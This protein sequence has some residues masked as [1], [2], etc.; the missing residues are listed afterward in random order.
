MD[1]DHVGQYAISVGAWEV[2]GRRQSPGGQ[3]RDLVSWQDPRY[4]SGSVA[5]SSLTSPS[6]PW[7]WQEVKKW[8]GLR[9]SEQELEAKVA[10]MSRSGKDTTKV[11]NQLNQIGLQIRKIDQFLVTQSR[12]AH[13]TT[14]HAFVV[15]KCA[16]KI[17]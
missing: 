11:L 12:E 14:G 7:S 8:A 17:V 1:M 10:K 2:V 4:I 16:Q 6:L 9:L 13:I 15:F 3:A 5:C